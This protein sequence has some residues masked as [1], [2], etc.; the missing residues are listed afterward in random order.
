MAEKK[1]ID[2]HAAPETGQYDNERVKYENTTAM[3]STLAALSMGTVDP[4]FL[5]LLLCSQLRARGTLVVV[6]LSNCHR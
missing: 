2:R 1:K 5:L 3:S 6:C 4:T